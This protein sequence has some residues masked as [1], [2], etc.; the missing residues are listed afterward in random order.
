MPDT[1]SSPLLKRMPPGVWMVLVWCAA[2]TYSL[3][4]DE[5]PGWSRWALLFAREEYAVPRWPQLAV[6]LLLVVCAGLPRV[7]PLPALAL[8]LTGTIVT[9]AALSVKDIP[10]PQFLAVDVALAFVAATRPRRTSLAAGAMALTALVGYAAAR[11]L[12]GMLVSASS[13]MVVALT[14][15]IAWLI[16]DSI[17]QSRVHAEALNAR[18]AQ[19]AITE[20]RLRIARELHDMVAHSIGIVAIQAGVGSR[21]IDSQPAEARKALSAIEA[22][23]RETL[24]GLRRMLGALRRAEARPVPSPG[25]GERAPEPA[26]GLADVERLAQRATAAGVRTDVCWKGERSPLPAEVDAAAYRIIQEAVT[27][28]LRHAGARHCR[29]TVDRREGE[30]YVEVVDDGKGGAPAGGAHGTDG[31]GW[32]IAGMR[33]RAGL[34]SGRFSAGP[35][36]GGG[37]RVEAGLPVPTGPR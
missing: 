29:V 15:V 8:L 35:W 18:A 19:Q 26:T 3:V 16:G 5:P 24:S 33:E 9:T 14:T 34:L 1:P 25:G 22:T 32:G 30:L 11:V 6:A 36:S 12:L 13:V 4:L 17:H 20:E 31:T 23:S 10:L 7:R 28:V 21:V 27:N 2:T 37:F